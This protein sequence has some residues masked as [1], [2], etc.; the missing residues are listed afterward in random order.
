MAAISMSIKVLM[1]FNKE[2]FPKVGN[3]VYEMSFVIKK[4]VMFRVGFLAE[5]R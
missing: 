3:H 5:K 4:K 1:N 2:Q